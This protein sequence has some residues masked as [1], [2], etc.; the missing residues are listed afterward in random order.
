MR[1]PA[2]SKVKLKKNFSLKT[3]ICY[4]HRPNGIKFFI[5]S[6]LTPSYLFVIL[7]LMYIYV[8]FGSGPMWT[9]LP[10]STMFSSCNKYWWTNILYI[11]NFYPTKIADQVRNSIN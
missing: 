7:I 10:R 4:T 1:D 5:Y 3:D 2:V 6:R 11:N 9:L 8:Y